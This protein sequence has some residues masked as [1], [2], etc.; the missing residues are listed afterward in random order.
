[1]IAINTRKQ[2]PS[3]DIA[4]FVM[5]LLILTQHTSNEWAHSTGI[6]HA[7]LGLGN[8]AV[9]FFFACS[10]FL[11]FS[12][13]D[14]LS[15]TGRA[16]YYKMWSIRIGKMYLVWSTIYFIFV[17]CSWF[18]NGFEWSKP[19]NWL[20]RAIVFS[21]Y[22]TIWF[23]PA[24]WL[25]VTICCWLKRKF[26][27]TI[28]IVIILVL[29]IVGNLFGSY[30]NIMTTWNPI[31]TAYHW[32]M[33]VFLTW[34]NGLFNGAPYVYIGILIAAG[35]LKTLHLDYCLSLTVLFCL[36]FL[37]EAFCIKHFHLSSA[38]DMGFMMA[39]AIY[40]MMGSLVKL[41]LNTHDLWIHCR[42][43]SMLVFLGQRLFL[44]AIPGVW[45]QMRLWLQSLSQPMVFMYFIVVVLA[46]ALII[47]RMSNR[48]KLLKLLW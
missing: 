14:T 2:Y 17:V 38:T 33:D 22:A 15:E 12:K 29:M 1:M 13:Y 25:G 37:A 43:L 34:R 24:L 45:P 8:F 4:K 23:L 30:S 35:R 32:Y 28:Q 39:P 5:A 40:F 10:G 47:E 16:D 6:V 9:P 21:T 48:Y 44:S 42:N 7:L 19:L 31:N 27:V 46:F 3:L 11:F 41:Q 20:H 26:S 36:A 18:N